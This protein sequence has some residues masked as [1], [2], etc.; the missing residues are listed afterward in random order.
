MAVVSVS[1]LMACIVVCLLDTMDCQCMASE[2]PALMTWL[3]QDNPE[4][5]CKVCLGILWT[6]KCLETEVGQGQ[7][8]WMLV[9]PN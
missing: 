4:D 1:L 7:T 3:C 2:V 6:L 8:S 5:F 9:D